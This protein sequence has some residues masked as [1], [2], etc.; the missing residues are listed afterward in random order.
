MAGSYSLKL[1][2][3]LANSQ[4]KALSEVMDWVKQLEQSNAK[5]QQ[6]VNQQTQELERCSQHLKNV[7]N[8]SHRMQRHLVQMEK[9]AMLGQM[10]SGISHEINNP[11]N[12]LY[13]N[14]PYVEAH[15][16]DLL[17][18]LQAYQSSNPH[19]TQA[20]QA[21]LEEVELDFVLEDLP[22]IVSSIK[23]GTDR[24]R[25]LVLTLR[26]FYR[27]DE[28]EMKPADLHEGI[29]NTLLLLQH[30]YKQE[31]EIVREFGDIPLIECHINQLNQVFMNLLSN[32]IDAL[33]EQSPDRLVNSTNDK[34]TKQIVIKTE[35]LGSDRLAVS[36]TDNGPG[37]PLEVQD[38]L[39]EP[40][41]TTKPMGIGTGLGL[42][43]S[44]Q[45]VTENHQGR[46]FCCSA[47]SG[48]TTFMVE[49]PLWQKREDG[50]I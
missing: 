33:L 37:I 17:R 7:L 1:I 26:N 15:V 5:L 8:D 50:G 40:F 24:I 11:I 21:V 34:A 27:L 2:Y 9:M 44:Y 20:V 29:N 25:E 19:I 32:A 6:K 41:F 10:V 12:F 4:S 14:L 45:I 48:G 39:F 31:V 13:G 49:L 3:S 42:S 23:L 38:R 46:I 22:R 35:K 30:R 47:P 43:I 28:P 36:I 18:V 16:E